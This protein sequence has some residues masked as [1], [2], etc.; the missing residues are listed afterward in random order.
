MEALAVLA[1]LARQ[2]IDHERQALGA[3]DTAM[4]DTQAEIERLRQS[5]ADERHAAI[6]GVGDAFLAAYITASRKRERSLLTRLDALEQARVGQV[7]RLLE[8]RLGLKR[9]ELL[10]ARRA[11]R[12]KT[13][14]QRAD[15]QALEDLIQARNGRARDG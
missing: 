15:R 9:L 11:E 2:Q 3:L 6:P 1:R 13:A 8:Q 7:E 10:A 12:N 14:L 5:V 4:A